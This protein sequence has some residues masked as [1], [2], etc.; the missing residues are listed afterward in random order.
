MTAALAWKDENG[1]REAALRLLAWGA[2]AG[3]LIFLAS[4]P[5]DTRV[6]ALVAGF[7]ALLAM[8]CVLNQWRRGES[9]GFAGTM[10]FAAIVSIVDVPTHHSRRHGC[11]AA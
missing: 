5:Q 3:L 8:L 1:Y 11:S 10:A 7:P 6:G 2:M 9:A 4:P